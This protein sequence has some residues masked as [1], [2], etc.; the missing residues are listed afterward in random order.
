VQT[1]VIIMN[2]F[3][4]FKTNSGLRPLFINEV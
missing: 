4:E 2:F 1:E 3:D